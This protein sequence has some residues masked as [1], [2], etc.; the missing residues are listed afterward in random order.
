MNILD[1]IFAHK[2]NELARQK[3]RKPLALVREEAEKTRP[4]MDFLAALAR[5]LG[6]A[7]IPY[8]S[9]IPALI[10]EVKRASPSKGELIQGFDPLNLARIYQRSG[11]SAI[12]VLTDERFFMGSLE[13]L[14][15]IAELNLG[16]PLLRKDFICDPYQVYQARGAGAD[17]VLLITASLQPGLLCDL[18][19]LT[20]ELGMTPLV[21]VHNLAELELALTCSPCAVPGRA[22]PSALIGVNNRNLRDFTASLE[23]TAQLK[24]YLP[25]GV[26][27]VAESGIHTTE[28]VHYL[29]ELGVDAMLIGEALVTAVDISAKIRSLLC[30]P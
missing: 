28:D 7:S 21:E 23:V 26:K 16:V 12:S 13:Y 2:Q 25:A 30:L 11:A 19:A 17:A 1:Q 18:H 15:A 6:L 9:R 4:A 27:L 14:R 29:A 10:A 5:P 20:C 24:P 3:Q 22:V 8:P